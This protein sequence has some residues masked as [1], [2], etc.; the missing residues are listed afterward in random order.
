MPCGNGFGGIGFAGSGG[1]VSPGADL[2]IVVTWALGDAAWMP[3][4]AGV[5]VLTIG[6]GDPGTPD[7]VGVAGLR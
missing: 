6:F 4:D 3:E 2:G 1:I 7:A 5:T